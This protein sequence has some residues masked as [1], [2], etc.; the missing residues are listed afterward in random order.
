MLQWISLCFSG[1]ICFTVLL[2]E[3]H[4]EAGQS[5]RSLQSLQSLRLWSDYTHAPAAGWQSV[6]AF[7]PWSPRYLLPDDFINHM[8]MDI[9]SDS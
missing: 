2:A 3:V 5:L 7:K 9:D 8:Y 1:W 6:S 4:W